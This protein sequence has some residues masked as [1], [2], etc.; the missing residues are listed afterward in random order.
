M[1]SEWSDWKWQT[2]LAH[3][4]VKVGDPEQ[5]VKKRGFCLCIFSK[6]DHALHLY[7]I[8]RNL[9]GYLKPES[10]SNWLFSFP[11]SVL[12]CLIVA[13]NIWVLFVEAWHYLQEEKTQYVSLGKL[14]GDILQSFSEGMVTFW[15]SPKT[16]FYMF[17]S[18]LG[19]LNISI[20]N[21]PEVLNF[22]GLQSIY[23]ARATAQAIL[24]L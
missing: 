11:F 3:L 9:Y 1:D 7:R 5:N 21:T 2:S 12:C 20:V 16:S 23:V 19:C 4:K 22:S 24:I 15:V 18:Q 6:G 17:L 14:Q 10:L 8:Y 13:C